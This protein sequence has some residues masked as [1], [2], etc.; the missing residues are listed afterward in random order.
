MLRK[1]NEKKKK[2]KDDVYYVQKIDDLRK[3]K[4]NGKDLIIG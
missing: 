1:Q 4:L 3:I 2:D